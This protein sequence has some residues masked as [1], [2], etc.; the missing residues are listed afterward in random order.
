M[1]TNLKVMAIVSMMLVGAMPAFAEGVGSVGAPLSSIQFSELSENRGLSGRLLD[2]KYQE[3]RQ[4]RLPR[5]TLSTT[6]IR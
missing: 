6:S 3:Y 5:T 4:G 2:R 1:K